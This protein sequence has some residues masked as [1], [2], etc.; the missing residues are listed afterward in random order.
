MKKI[1]TIAIIIAVAVV[2]VALFV[3]STRQGQNTSLSSPSSTVSLPVVSTT[4]AS[5]ERPTGNTLQ[6]GTQA[7]TV[8][9]NNFYKNPAQVSQDQ[10]S[11]IIVQ[12]NAYNITYY[13]PDS[14]FNIGIWQKPVAAVRTQAEAAF[15]AA[16]GISKTDACKLKVQI[17][18]PYSVDPDYADKNLGLS[19]CAPSTF[20]G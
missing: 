12:T 16:L 4:S 15:L 2:I 6:I 10:T 7:G 18:V 19:F 5:V 9:L 13:V 11:I 17:G 3:F 20:G 8:T 1:I 14:S